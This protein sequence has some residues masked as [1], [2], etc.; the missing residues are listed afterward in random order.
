MVNMADI[1]L[2]LSEIINKKKVSLR[3]VIAYV[4]TN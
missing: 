1:D 3:Y 4:I 2:P